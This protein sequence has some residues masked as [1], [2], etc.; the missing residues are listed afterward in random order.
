MNGNQV[1]IRRQMDEMR[2]DELVGAVINPIQVPAEALKGLKPMPLA[3]RSLSLQAQR[4]PQLVWFDDIPDLLRGTLPKRIEYWR[5]KGVT[6]LSALVDTTASVDAVT[7]HL[8]DLFF[9]P[10]SEDGT[11]ALRRFYDPRVFLHLPWILDRR[12]MMSVMGPINVWAW[13]DGGGG[14]QYHKNDERFALFKPTATRLNFSQKQ[15]VTLS[16]LPLIN[17]VSEALSAS[18]P[19][20]DQNAAFFRSVDQLLAEAK[21]KGIVDDRDCRLYVTQAFQFGPDIHKH[22]DMEA[23]CIK[24]TSSTISYV[25]ACSDL[26]DEMLAHYAVEGKRK[27]L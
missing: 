19:D 11:V 4:L 12:Q 27:V 6:L 23:C 16:R 1:V 26:S 3:P 10:A 9:A 15:K 13:P 17:Q 5:H 21:E 24:A 14:W 25:E 22:P 20:F 8:Q 7:R 18:M 2:L